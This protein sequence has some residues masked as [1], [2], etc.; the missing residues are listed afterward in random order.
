MIA[1]VRTGASPLGHTTGQGQKIAGELPCN[2]SIMRVNPDGSGLELVAWG[3]RNPFGVRF[4]PDGYLYVTDN[5][6]DQHGSRP[7]GGDDLL[8][9]IQPGAWYGWPDYWNGAPVHADDDARREKV[10]PLL[11]QAPARPAKALAAL[12]DHVGATGFDF[13]PAA[14][15]FPGQMFIAMWGSGFPATTQESEPAGFNVARFDLTTGKSVFA[16]NKVPGPASL[17]RRGRV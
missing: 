13:A 6:P 17:G 3:L 10:Q 7:F 16:A 2:G 4:G 1:G 5:G 9:R 12:G 11:E 14:F 15:G 8:H